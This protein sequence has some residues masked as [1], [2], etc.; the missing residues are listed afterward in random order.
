M[1]RGV[2]VVSCSRRSLRAAERHSRRVCGQGCRESGAK[3]YSEQ[4]GVLMNTWRCIG[5]DERCRAAVQLG[6]FS[7]V[8]AGAL[9]VSLAAASGRFGGLSLLGARHWVY[10]DGL[11]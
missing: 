6:P 11:L 1:D 4:A 5:E 10:F 2:A 9:A 7:G 8:C 3:L